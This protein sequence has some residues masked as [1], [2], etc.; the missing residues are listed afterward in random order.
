MGF[1]DNE[2][3]IEETNDDK[4]DEDPKKEWPTGNGTRIDLIYSL[5][6]QAVS[7]SSDKVNE[8]LFRLSAEGTFHFHTPYWAGNTPD[9]YDSGRPAQLEKYRQ[10]KF[11]QGMPTGVQEFT[12]RYLTGNLG[13]FA[14]QSI[15][16][17]YDA[18]KKRYSTYI[19][20]RDTVNLA[21]NEDNKGGKTSAAP[22][23]KQTDDVSQQ[24]KSSSMMFSAT[25]QTGYGGRCAGK[26]K[27]IS[28]DVK[29][30]HDRAKVTWASMQ[31]TLYG[32]S[33]TLVGLPNFVN[34]SCKD[35]F[36][37]ILV[38]L[39]DRKESNWLGTKVIDNNLIHWS[40]GRYHIASVTHV[41]SGAAYNIMVEMSRNYHMEGL[42]DAKEGAAPTNKA[43]EVK[44]T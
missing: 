11:L 7:A 42:T 39:P 35:K 40:S 44:T 30:V 34:L 10:F 19:L 43:E 29:E 5:L 36:Y 23:T 13:L 15:S 17:V 4:N 3:F 2:I 38:I 14:A 21:S 6:S 33:M 16:A 18:R 20:N 31:N 1:K 28:E 32:A 12:P 8:Y 22:L 27:Q 26:T 24:I 41:I 37:D 25:K 9:V